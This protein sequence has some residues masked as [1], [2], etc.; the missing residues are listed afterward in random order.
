MFTKNNPK[1]GFVNGTLGVVDGFDK[2]TG[3]PIVKIRNGRKI[4][5]ESMD[6]TIEENGKIKARISQLPLRLAWAI[7]VHKSQGMSLD[8]AV[9]DLS[10]VFE[11]GQGYV[12]LLPCQT[13]YRFIHFGLERADISGSPGNTSKRQR[14]PPRFKYYRGYVF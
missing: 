14:I 10:Q 12:A 8:E 2:I 7:T 11:Y 3:N 6:W 1:E 13:S 5:V 9:M 4:E